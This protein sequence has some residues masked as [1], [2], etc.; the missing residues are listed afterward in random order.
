MPP[1]PVLVILVVFG[2]T[3]PVVDVGGSPVNPGII[4]ILQW[5]HSEVPTVMVVDGNVMAVIVVD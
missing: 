3:V 1:V 2:N 5:V 4:V